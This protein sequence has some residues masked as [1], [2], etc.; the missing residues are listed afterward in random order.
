[1]NRL[2]IVSNRLPF[3]VIKKQGGFEL[4]PSSG[5]L[6]SGLGSIYTHFNSLWIGWPGIASDKIALHERNRIRGMLAEKKCYPVFLSQREVERY[7]NGFCNKTLWPLFH[8]FMQHAT[9]NDQLFESYLRASEVFRDAIQRVAEPND[10]IWIHDYH[11]LMLPRL[12]REK[13]RDAMIG[14]FLHIPFPSF[15]VFRLLPWREEVLRGVLGSDFIGFH[16]YDYV[17]HFLESVHRLLGYEHSVGRISTDDRLVQA[18]V[19]PMGIN[20]DRFSQAVESPP[21]KRE[22]AR[23]RRKTQ[24]RKII[25]SIDRLDYSKGIPERLEAF[26]LFL[27]K[28]P[29]FKEKVT[30]V[31]L[32]VPSRTRIDHYSQLKRQIEELIGKINGKHGTMGWI[33]IWYLYRSLPFSSLVALYKMADVALITPM[34]DGMNLIAKE[35]LAVKTDGMGVLILSEMT[36]AAQEMGEAIIINPNN[37]AAIAEAIKEALIMPAEKQIDRNRLMRK[38]LQR[39]DAGNWANDFIARLLATKT[40]QRK[41]TMKQLTPA[42]WHMLRRRYANSSKRLLLLDYDGTMV[43]FAQ[44][45]DEAYP[46]SDLLELLE[47]LASD[48]NNTVVLV[49]GRDRATMETWFEDIGVDLV[50]E[51][52]LLVKEKDKEWVISEP[53]RTDWKESIR[54]ILE[55]YSDRTPGS[56]VEDKEFSLV[57][58]YRKASQELAAAVSNELKDVLHQL[59]SRLNLDIQEGKKVIEVKNI[60]VNKGRAV[61]RWITKTS[62]DFIM[63]IGDDATDEDVFSVVP[64][65]AFSIKVG[66]GRSKAKYQMESPIEVRALLS[67]IASARPEEPL[68]ASEKEE[69]PKSVSPGLPSSGERSALEP[70]DNS[71]SINPQRQD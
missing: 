27:D 44:K 51:H 31:L 49:S 35:F 32:A 9:Y 64:D 43:P 20:F 1:M 67:D 65:T 47:K 41:L 30:L 18:D 21:V 62:W 3:T 70:P 37:K 25:L 17:L 40:L 15:E 46:P 66:I 68:A 42:I 24:E 59:T 56:F 60:G 22:I 57:W 12:L 58:H 13:A 7:Y 14:F 19:F 52:G 23:I 38:R 53:I 33:P 54:P 6:A 48:P 11:L 50:A 61:L 2:I 55:L 26:D 29:E 34:R 10:V 39:Y 36:G 8:Y 5:G 4:Q 69:I 16:T 45:P 28:Y 71:A 63:A